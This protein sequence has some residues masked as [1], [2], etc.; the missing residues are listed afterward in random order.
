MAH[1]TYSSKKNELFSF[2][3]IPTGNRLRD[4]GVESLSE[5]LK[6]NTTLTELNLCGEDK[7]KARKWNPLT[8]R[9]SWSHLSTETEIGDTGATSLSESLKSNTTLTKLYLSGESKEKTK[10]RRP[11]TN[12]SFSFIFTRTVNYIGDTGATSLSEALKLNTSLTALNLK[13]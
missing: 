1:K 6:S 12:G 10:K 2:F 8:I 13:C 3:I 7:R 5:A 11:S 9:S 4:T